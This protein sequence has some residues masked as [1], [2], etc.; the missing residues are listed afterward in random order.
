M[1]QDNDDKES[2]YRELEA[3]EFKSLIPPHLLG[4]LSEQEKYLVET[5]SVLGQQ[6]AWLINA[7]LEGNKANI[8]LDR[9]VQSLV[10][11]RAVLTSKWSLGAAALMVCIP[12]IVKV[13][14]EQ[15][16]KGP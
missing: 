9:K 16:L 14:I 5:L 13:V 2:K 1:S 12:V 4:K 10:R 15:W 11:W 6:N 8:E 3:P 7:T